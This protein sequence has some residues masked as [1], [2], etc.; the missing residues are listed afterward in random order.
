MKLKKIGMLLLL[1]S[2]I[3]IIFAL[4]AGC[5]KETGA[6][7]LSEAVLTFVSKE[8]VE[9]GGAGEPLVEFQ[10]E[11]RTTQYVL[12]GDGNPFIDVLRDFTPEK[13]NQYASVLAELQTTGSDDLLSML[14][15]GYIINS[16][17]VISGDGMV[18]VDFSSE[19]LSGSSMQEYLLISQIVRTLCLSFENVNSVQFTVDGEVVET[20][21]GHMMIS[22]PFE[23]K[24]YVDENGET[25]YSVEAAVRF[26]A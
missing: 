24:S 7:E 4:S 18:I 23:L 21:M 16:A 5:A 22:S 6:E 15:S 20:L 9:T 14:S 13:D 10:D 17:Q 12:S 11:C 25:Y 2:L 8:Y 19:G 3:V 1:G 26:G